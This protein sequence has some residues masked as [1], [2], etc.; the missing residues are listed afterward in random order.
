M[1]REP[2]ADLGAILPAAFVE[3]AVLILSR[4]GIPFGFGV[5]QQDQTAHVAIS[6]RWD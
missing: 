3:A 5:T 1:K 6:F 4:R 2:S